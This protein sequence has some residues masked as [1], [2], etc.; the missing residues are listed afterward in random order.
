[1]VGIGAALSNA[2]GGVLVQRISFNASFLGLAA[3]GVAAFA[4]LFFGVPETFGDT[5]G[6][7]SRGLESGKNS[8]QELTA[9]ASA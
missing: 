5:S 3:V 6:R 9:K 1:M 4:V 8:P 2:I 7:S